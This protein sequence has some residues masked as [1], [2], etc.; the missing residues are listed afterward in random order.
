LG[1]SVQNFTQLGGRA[2]SLRLSIWSRVSG[3]MGFCDQFDKGTAS[4]FVQISGKSA[5][6][7]LVKVRQEFG[8]KA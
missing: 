5:A 4:N 8:K 2:D 1:A 3:L 6:E 7:T